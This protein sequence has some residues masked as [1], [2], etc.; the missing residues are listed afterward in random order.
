MGQIT[1]DL[2]WARY[3]ELLLCCSCSLGEIFW[4]TPASAGLGSYLT[5]PTKQAHSSC[6]KL[7]CSCWVAAGL[8]TWSTPLP[9]YFQNRNKW[10]EGYRIIL[11]W[12]RRQEES[13]HLSYRCPSFPSSLLPSVVKWYHGL[14]LR[15]KNEG[16]FQGAES[17]F[18]HRF[19]RYNCLG[20]L[21]LGFQK[22]TRSLAPKQ[23]YIGFGGTST[24]KFTTFCFLCG[25]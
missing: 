24:H 7:I 22:P 5:C 3:L 18:R 19:D 23:V 8:M 13:H 20:A 15:R 17:P 6:L 12:L 21:F 4:P 16:R 2:S 10:V 1:K 25:I 9:S 14:P 11:R